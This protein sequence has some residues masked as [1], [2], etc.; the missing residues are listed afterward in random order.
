[1]TICVLPCSQH[2]SVGIPKERSSIKKSLAASSNVYCKAPV[3]D[4]G[5]GGVITRG[6]ALCISFD[7]AAG[8]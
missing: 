2:A 7:A 4:V 5:C 6:F 1:V 3:R 8:M